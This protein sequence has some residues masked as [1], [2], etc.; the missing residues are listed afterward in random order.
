MS[1]GAVRAAVTAMLGN[2]ENITPGGFLIPIDVERIAADLEI[3]KRATENGRRNFPPI[4]SDRPDSVEQSIAQKVESEWTL[5]GGHLINNLRAYASR[6]IGYSVQAEFAKLQ[7]KA[8]DALTKLRSAHHR[9]EA[10]LG[11]LQK[12]YLESRDE[13]ARFRVRHHLQRP[14]RNQSGRWTSVGLLVVLVAIESVLN[15]FFFAKGSEF[16]LVGGI[17]TAIGISICNV[18]FAFVLGLGPLRWLNHRNLL[19][20]LSGLILGVAG[21]AAIVA[22]HAFA[23]HLRDAT[24]AVGE[25]QALNAAV[26]SLLRAPWAV[27]DHLSVYLFVLGTLFGLAAVGKGYSFDDPYPQYG[28]QSRRADQ[29]RLGYSDA[30]AE[31]FDELEDIKQETVRDLD[32]GITRIPLFPQEVARIRAE[33]AAMLQNFHAHESGIVTA[34]NQLLTRYRD[35]NREHRTTDVPPYFSRPWA[36]PHSF[37]QNAEISQLTAEPGT[38]EPDLASV[39]SELRSLSKEVLGEFESLMTKY[40]HT[41]QM[42]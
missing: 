27:A 29:A 12:S 8:S 39:L 31:T 35:K 6:L 26:T 10:E 32:D 21:L 23:A 14:V 36:L 19:I 42:A 16:G 41:S 18:G 15:G 2:G 24:A 28:P 9:A 38:P 17:G 40:P 33:R 37:L 22:L 25:E 7:L 34:A 13:Y 3:D 4:D 20:K 11:H 30:H 1:V 5:H